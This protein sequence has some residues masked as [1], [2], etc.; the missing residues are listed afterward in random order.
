MLWVPD[1]FGSLLRMLKNTSLITPRLQACFSDLEPGCLPCGRGQLQEHRRLFKARFVGWCQ[2]NLAAVQHH[3]SPFPH[4]HMT[5]PVQLAESTS[6][7]Q[8]YS[9][10]SS[11]RSPPFV[12]TR[13][14]SETT[15][16]G[17]GQSLTKEKKRLK[18]D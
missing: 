9:L 18:R 6:L 2:S 13:F 4:R 1:V 3:T 7:G 11:T 15:G 16:M 10:T 17:R 5:E 14:S 12:H 8:N